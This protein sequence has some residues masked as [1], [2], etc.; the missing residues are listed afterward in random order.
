MNINHHENGVDG[1]KTALVDHLYRFSMFDCSYSYLIIM[2][3][4][5]FK[6]FNI[7]LIS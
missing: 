7:I 5:Y 1:E 6:S 4:R 2:L 3:H